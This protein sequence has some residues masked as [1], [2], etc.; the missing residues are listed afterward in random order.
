M[1]KRTES[2][3]QVP[4]LGSPMRRESFEWVDCG[5]GPSTGRFGMQKNQKVILTS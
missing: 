3:L 2:R 1:K 4:M 5:R